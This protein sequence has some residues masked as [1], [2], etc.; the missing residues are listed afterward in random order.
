MILPPPPPPV[1][2]A[3][4]LP[5]L[6][7]VTLPRVRQLV[8]VSPAAPD[9]VST[10]RA[11]HVAVLAAPNETVV[12]V[13]ML[14]L[15]SITG[16]DDVPVAVSAPVIVVVVACGNATQLGPLSVNVEN[17]LAPEKATLPPLLFPLMVVG[18]NENPP[19]AHVHK[20]VLVTVQFQVAPLK[21][22]PWSFVVVAMEKQPLTVLLVRL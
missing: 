21:T 12:T 9:V 13:S 22:E 18:P 20:F 3:V 14:L 17:V 2:G 19:P 16:V 5:P 4:Q 6:A 11:A 8:A 10:L 1:D 15:V 7:S